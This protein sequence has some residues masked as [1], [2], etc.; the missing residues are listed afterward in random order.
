M[1][2]Q[3]L[4]TIIT[5]LSLNNVQAQLWNIQLDVNPTTVFAPA[6]GLSAVAWTGSEF[7]V[8]KWADN[9]IYTADASGN[10]TGNFTIPG[11]TGTR[12]ITTDGV[13]MYIG[14]AATVIYQVNPIT[15]TLI[16]T[17]NTSVAA[18]RYVTFDPGLDNG[19]GGFWAGAYASDITSVNMTGQTLSIISATT[20]G[21]S[22]I[23]GMAYDGYSTGGPYLWA[24]DQGGNNADIIQLT[25]LGVPTGIMHDAQSD[26][27]SG[28][29]GGTAGG[30]F[31]CNNYMPGTN[32][33]IGINQG[34]SL[35]SYELAD[36][37]TDDAIL[38]NLDIDA[39]VVNPTNVDIKGTIKNGGLNPITSIDV[40]WSDG[41]NTYTDNLT[42]LNITMNGT[43]NFTHSTQLVVNSLAANSLTVWLEYPADLD[44][45]NNT[46]TTTVGGVSPIPEKF[47]VGEEKTGSWCGWCPRGAVALAEMEA[48][49][50]FIGIAVHNN[51]PM[52]ISSYD[53][54]IGT[55]VPGGYPGGGV[56]RV[57]DGDPSDFS[58]LHNTRVNDIV[59]CGVNSI[60]ASFD[61]TTNKI[62]ISTQ[63]EAFGEMSG[64]FRLSCVIVEDDLISTGSGWAQ[65]NYYSGGGSGVMAFP[66]NVNG[67]YNFSTGNDPAQPGDFGGYDHVARSLSSNNILGDPNSLPAGL[68]NVG[69]YSYTFSD[70]STG[71]LIAYNAV[72]FDWTKAH[73]IVMIVNASTGEILNAKKAALSINNPASSWDCDPING[74]I[75]PGTGNGQYNSITACNIACITD[76]S[77]NI[78]N[79]SIYPNPI[80]NTLN[81]KG[82]YTYLDVFDMFGKLILSSKY[83]TSINVSTLANGIYMLN[84]HTEKGTKTQKITITK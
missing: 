10:M 20:H 68:V 70:V 78:A 54:G 33:M 50:N 5:L 42:G 30:L 80:K 62:S 12:S 28:V 81:I 75:D 51:D 22:G 57:L 72:G 55:Y 15:R 1:R 48:T 71:S 39:Y 18:C 4:T 25:I 11:I 65:V 32:S 67:G 63:I 60:N 13:N 2:T 73:A 14:T 45:S 37:P 27:Q 36:P 17:I 61:G 84:I 29:G 16:S 69:T 64:N 66:P 19:N 35:F 83:A 79:L 9:N 44:V 47:T 23:Y 59:P 21:L 6:T 40:K 3:I 38:S 56:D 58:M 24:F 76:I 49:P 46:L 26:L 82:T 53:G 7:W 34:V 43:Y 41:T 52:A 31:I 77:E 74:C 8:S